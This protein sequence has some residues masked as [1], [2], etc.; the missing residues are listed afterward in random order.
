M[1]EKLQE[2]LNKD[3][4]LMNALKCYSITHILCKTDK[5]ELSLQLKRGDEAYAL[6]HDQIPLTKE[7]STFIIKHIE[8]L[9][10]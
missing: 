7:E 6:I 4:E 2:Q 3:K 8:H 5:G 10:K 9:I 1:I